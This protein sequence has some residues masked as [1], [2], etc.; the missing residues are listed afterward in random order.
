MQVPRSSVISSQRR[1][2]FLYHKV[3]KNWTLWFD[4]NLF[5]FPLDEIQKPPSVKRI[6]AEKC[7]GLDEGES[8]WRTLNMPQ[9]EW[10]DTA[11]SCTASQ[12]HAY[13]PSSKEKN[14]WRLK[15]E[16][17]PWDSLKNVYV[18]KEPLQL[19][20][21]HSTLVPGPSQILIQGNSSLRIAWHKLCYLWQVL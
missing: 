21:L 18:S 7:R 14:R 13:S 10:Y 9:I 16:H 17:L 5:F 6:C 2:K 19:T 1:K 20:C 12:T 3:L 4:F 8:K 11:T 15:M